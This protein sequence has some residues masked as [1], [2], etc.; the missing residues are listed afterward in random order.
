MGSPDDGAPRGDKCRSVSVGTWTTTAASATGRHVD[1]SRRARASTRA[2]GVPRVDSR[3][4]RP[5]GRLGAAGGHVAARAKSTVGG[6]PADRRQ[7]AEQ[8]RHFTTVRKTNTAKCIDCI[9]ETDGP[10]RLCSIQ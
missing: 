10:R 3:G 6:R 8:W 4:A 2:A 5:A 1:G 7:L 9:S